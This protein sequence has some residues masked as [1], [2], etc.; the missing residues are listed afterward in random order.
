MLFLFSTLFVL[1]T[2]LVLLVKSSE[3]L[4]DDALIIAR[5]LKASDL[6]IGFF[7]VSIATTLPELFVSIIASI[8][9]EP[10]L[11]LGNV[12]GSNIANLSL[13]LGI[14]VFTTAITLKKAERFSLLF[15]LGIAALIS[16]SLFFVVPSGLFGLVLLALFLGLSVFVLTRREAFTKKLKYEVFLSEVVW[17]CFSFLFFLGI[18]LLSA[19]LVIK[20]SVELAGLIGFSKSFI[21]ATAIAL[22]TSLPELTVALTACR[23]HRIRLALGNLLGAS[24][25]NLTLVLGVAALFA[26]VAASKITLFVLLAFCLIIYSLLFSI[27]YFNKSLRKSDGVVLL[28]VYSLF[29]LVGFWV[30]GF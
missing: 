18:L 4:I 26:P 3:R 25:T 14:V 7:L 8:E 30:Q 21:G 10:G 13:I 15:F 1:A 24:V 28:F 23:K 5:F 12:L 17:A 11:V 20:T 27:L 9:G 6:V 19:D 29:L 16:F 22:G 2:G